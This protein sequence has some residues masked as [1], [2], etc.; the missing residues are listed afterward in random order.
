MS[1]IQWC[2]RSTFYSSPKTLENVSLIVV[3][4][5]NGLLKRM[6]VWS[7]FRR[8]SQFPHNSKRGIFFPFFSLKYT[9]CECITI[10]YYV[11]IHDNTMKIT[12]TDEV[13]E[14]YKKTKHS[15]SL[16]QGTGPFTSWRPSW[17]LSSLPSLLPSWPWPSWLRPS[18]G[19]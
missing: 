2:W 8:Q 19:L 13:W 5:S 6:L 1:F 17:L 12:C 7:F 11:R 18:W 16:D 14:I 4:D 15:V 3:H 10:P 9:E